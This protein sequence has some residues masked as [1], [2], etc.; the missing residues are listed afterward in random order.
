MYFCLTLGCDIPICEA[1]FFHPAQNELDLLDSDFTLFCFH[2]QW[3]EAKP[4][5]KLLNY[6]GELS[7]SFLKIVG[8]KVSNRNQLIPRHRFPLVKGEWNRIDSLD[9]SDCTKTEMWLDACAKLDPTVPGFFNPN[10]EE[11][12]KAAMT[13][14]LTHKQRTTSE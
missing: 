6:Y 8:G 3:K 5:V 11:I 13:S 4:L 7:W 12:R 10:S 14:I 1:I 2:A 9:I